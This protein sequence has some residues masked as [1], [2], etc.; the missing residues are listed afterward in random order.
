MAGVGRS[1]PR[2]GTAGAAQET[3]GRRLAYTS[4]QLVGVHIGASSLLINDMKVLPKKKQLATHH[5]RGRVF[6]APGKTI[7]T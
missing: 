7:N 2:G 6:E 3:G 4:Q 5:T 1:M